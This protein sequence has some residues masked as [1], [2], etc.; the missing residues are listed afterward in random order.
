MANDN[1][2]SQT[3]PKEQK[4]E[5]SLLITMGIVV[6]AAAIIAVIGFLCLNH[7]DNIV[8]GQVEGTTVRI[9]GKLP[10]R[11]VEFFVEEGDTVHAGDTLVHIHSGVVEAQLTQAEAMK[12]VASAQNRKVDAGTRRQIIQA[13]SDMVAQAQAAV[14]IAKKTYDR[15][16]N[17]YKEG[18]ISEQK[19]DE[20]KAAYDGSK[21][22]LATAQSNLSLAKAGAQSED[23]ESTA[24]MVQAAGGAVSQV[25]AVLEDSYLTAPNDGTIDQ[26]YPEPG[27]LVAMGTPIISLLRNDKRWITFNV[28]E[29][30]LEDLPMGKEIEVMVPALGQKKIKAEV[31]YIRDMGT[32]ATWRSTKSNGSWDSRTFEIKARPA[33]QVD[34]LRP[35]MSIIYDK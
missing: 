34:G 9:S 6:L 5:R 16:E 14:T 29:E 2:S 33:G 25:N 26:I 22:A 21:A 1:N 28:R 7:P 20:A 32:Y 3:Q 15:M 11:V 17:L 8:E 24:A 13:A 30:L 12:E 4:A 23:K 27:E 31:Y 35:G 10:G 18:V 19:R